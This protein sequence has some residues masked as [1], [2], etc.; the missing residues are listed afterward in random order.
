MKIWKISA[1][2]SLAALLGACGGFIQDDLA[3]VRG[4]TPQGSAFDAALHEG[5]LDL[6]HREAGELDMGNARLWLGKASAAADGA[7][8]VP[9][10]PGNWSLPGDKVDE[11]A[12]ARERLMAALGRGAGDKS[13]SQASRAQVMLECW[14]EEQYENVQP[15]DIAAC[16]YAFY[17][18]LNAAEVALRPPFKP[19]QRIA[20][21]EFKPPPPP[22]PRLKPRVWTIHFDFNE[23]TPRRQDGA[24]IFS[25]VG[26]A[27]QY[28]ESVKDLSQAAKPG[29]PVKADL[30]VLVRGHADRAGAGAYNDKLAEARAMEVRKVLIDAG[31]SGSFI[32]V[33]S[34]GENSPVVNTPDG[35]AEAANRRVQ[36]HVSSGR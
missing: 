24:K 5:Y 36:I 9:E 32:R 29:T 35:K 28:L 3:Q 11:I 10:E 34:F 14:I 8:V 20:K 25:V 33:Q 13:P 1:A 6:A 31:L 30:E 7:E 12:K 19:E 18:S 2:V 17:G 4:M 16:R 23:P 26:Y 21:A 22:T 27:Q 15:E